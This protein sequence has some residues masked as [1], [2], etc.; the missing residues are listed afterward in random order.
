MFAIFGALAIANF[1]SLHVNLRRYLTGADQQGLNLDE[2][3]EWWWTGF[4]VGPNAIWA[5]GSLAFAG[6]LW[7]LWGHLREPVREEPR[8]VAAR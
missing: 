5:I 3:T 7:I 6:L 1:V 8:P 2:G 4:P